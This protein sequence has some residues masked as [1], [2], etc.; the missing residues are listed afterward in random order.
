MNKKVFSIIMEGECENAFVHH[1]LRIKTKET[2]L[3]P[4]DLLKTSGWL[5]AKTV[6]CHNGSQLKYD[7]LRERFGYLTATLT[8]PY[9]EILLIIYVIWMYDIFKGN[10]CMKHKFTKH[11]ERH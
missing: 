4:L 7:L 3:W 9:L 8:H 6:P 11:L 10:L 1:P 2:L 5:C